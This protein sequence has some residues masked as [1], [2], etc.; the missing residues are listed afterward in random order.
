MTQAQIPRAMR[1]HARS[2][3]VNIL[4]SL[5]LRVSEIDAI[6]PP[7]LG[8]TQDAAAA[9]SRR[10]GDRIAKLLQRRMF[11]FGTKQ[12]FRQPRA[13]SAFGGKADSE[14]QGLYLRF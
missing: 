5:P 1:L 6:F 9:R 7:W 3:R 8:T 11:A 14:V 4:N 10:R 2:R 12:T 13:M